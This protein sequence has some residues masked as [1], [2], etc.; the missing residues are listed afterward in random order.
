MEIINTDIDKLLESTMDLEDENIHGM[1][2]T[3]EIDQLLEKTQD[4]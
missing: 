2:L 4:W 3:F 1:L